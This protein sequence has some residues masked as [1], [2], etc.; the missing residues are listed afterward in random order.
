MPAQF[1]MHVSSW[2]AL[3]ERP[4]GTVNPVV[5]LMRDAFAQGGGTIRAD[6][7]P[8]QDGMQLRLNADEG[9]I[10]LVGK[11]IGKRIDQR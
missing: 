1:V 10:R 5:E 9:F 2:L 6:L 11:A 8:V 7:K 4:D 3:M